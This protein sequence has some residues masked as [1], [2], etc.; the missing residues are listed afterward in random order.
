MCEKKR[1]KDVN[2]IYTKCEKKKEKTFDESK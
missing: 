2:S 1:K